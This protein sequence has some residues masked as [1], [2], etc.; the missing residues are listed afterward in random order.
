MTGSENQLT[1]NW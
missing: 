1:F